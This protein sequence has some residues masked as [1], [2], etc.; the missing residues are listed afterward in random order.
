MKRLTNNPQI[1]II[2]H[3]GGTE[4]DPLADTSH[5]TFIDVNQWHKQRWGYQNSLGHFIGY[6]YFIE[7]SGKT[8]LG[9][10]ENEEGMHTKGK[11]FESIGIC[12]AGNFDRL[13][14]YPT[15]EQK[16]AL[17]VLLGRLMAKYNITAN[18]IYPHREFSSKSCPGKNIS[19]GWT[20]RLV[21]EPEAPFSKIYLKIKVVELR[22]KLV[23]LLI[24]LF[25]LR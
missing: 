16:T 17:K 1:L 21:K 8:V 10:P 6:H 22:I 12:L 9:T 3:T 15:K 23:R 20:R 4:A 11:N 13:D 14:S 2:H 7:K 25:R 5:H 24:K 19:D 18:Y